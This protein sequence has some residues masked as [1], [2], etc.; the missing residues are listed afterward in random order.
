MPELSAS[1]PELL[2]A[3]EPEPASGAM[4]SGPC[5]LEAEESAMIFSPERRFDAKERRERPP[6]RYDKSNGSQAK[7]EGRGG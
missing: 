3:P 4:S 6:R 1:A 7:R 5:L 2:F